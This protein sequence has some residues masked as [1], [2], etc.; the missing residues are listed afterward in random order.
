M[1]LDTLKAKFYPTP[2]RET[3][4]ADAISHSTLK[5]KATKKKH[6]AKHGC[7]LEKTPTNHVIFDIETGEKWR[8]SDDNCALCFHFRADDATEC[9]ACP[10]AESRDGVPC[11]Q[12]AADEAISPWESWTDKCDSKPMREA[13]KKAAIWLAEHPL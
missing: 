5:W 1:S 2:A 8:F 3:A 11:H 12:E 9:N 6:L 10:L 4:K 7:A 13:L